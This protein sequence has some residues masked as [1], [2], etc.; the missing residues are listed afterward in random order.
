[1][2]VEIISLQ[3]SKGKTVAALTATA[4]FFSGL[5]N[6]AL[7]SQTVTPSG[8]VA[9][10]SYAAVNFPAGVSVNAST[11]AITGTPTSPGITTNASVTVTD[12]AGVPHTFSV[13]IFFD[14]AT[15]TFSDSFAR[16]DQPFF[17]GSQWSVFPL[18]GS[19]CTGPNIAAA[20]NVASNQLNL[21]ICSSNGLNELMLFP[22]PIDWSQM[23]THAQYAQAI[24]SADNS[25]PGVAVGFT[26]IGAMFNA[27][28]NTGYFLMTNTPDGGATQVLGKYNVF[29][30][31]GGGAGTVI[32]SNLN[33]A[34]GNTLRIEVKPNTP[35]ANQTTINSY[36]NGVLQSSDVDSTN[37]YSTGVYGIFD[38]FVSSGVTQSWK[39]FQG[40][41]L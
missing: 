21:T 2:T 20:I 10:Y 18:E 35:V 37:H 27:N 17:V 22:I 24:L 8:G 6:I 13:P 15:G 14:I 34:V 7:T 26:G 32:H 30:L 16:V 29:S 11:G 41:P 19:T 40:G 36:V 12:S 4:L 3:S 5:D 25:N 23:F 39:S 9:P 38:Y 33:F 28:N 1:M 31:N